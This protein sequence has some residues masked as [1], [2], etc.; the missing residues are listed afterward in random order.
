M[1]VFHQPYI[2]F[3]FPFWLSVC[4]RERQE[5]TNGLRHTHTQRTQKSRHLTKAICWARGSHPAEVWHC[6]TEH[7]GSGKKVNTAR[8]ALHLVWKAYSQPAL[9][10][11]WPNLFKT[12]AR[13]SC[14]WCM[15]WLEAFNRI[16]FSFIRHMFPTVYLEK[17]WKELFWCW[18][19]ARTKIKLKCFP[20]FFWLTCGL[21]LYLSYFR[22]IQFN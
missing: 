2:F 3:L 14:I 21:C 11:Y 16:F 12:C 15:M 9:F 13:L 8:S 7:C 5:H 20:T 22:G 6:V 10:N 4:E 18:L 1:N 17:G 19:E